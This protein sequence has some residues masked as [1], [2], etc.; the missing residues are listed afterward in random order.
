MYFRCGRG[1]GYSDWRD[2]AL[3]GES[4][5]R[6]IP[7]GRGTVY[8]CG[9]LLSDADMRRLV[10]MAS[11]TAGIRRYETE[12]SLQVIP[13]IAGSDHKQYLFIAETGNSPAKI[14]LTGPMKDILTGREHPA[15]WMDAKPYQLSV[16]EYTED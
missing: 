6:R 7:Y 2:S 4:V 9:A 8:L 14:R 1:P 16:L 15:G 11:D 5:A 12:G 13:R 3:I 10:E